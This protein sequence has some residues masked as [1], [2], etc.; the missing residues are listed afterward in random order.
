MVRNLNKIPIDLGGLSLLYNH[1]LLLG[2]PLSLDRKLPESQNTL[3]EQI[4]IA[5]PE[6]QLQTDENSKIVGSS[7]TGREIKF[8]LI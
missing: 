1:N 7:Q 4:S 3:D 8:Q 2:L 5:T 6:V